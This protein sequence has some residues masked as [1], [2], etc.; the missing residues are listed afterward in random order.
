MRRRL[1]FITR[2]ATPHEL[3][4]RPLERVAVGRTPQHDILD[5]AR[6]R[7]V[8][9]G[10]AASAVRGQLHRDP[11]PRHRQIGMVICRL[12]QVANRI[13]Q[14][15]RRRPPIG[16][17]DPTDPSVFEGTA[18]EAPSAAQRSVSRRRLSLSFAIAHSM[19]P[20][21]NAQ[22]PTPKDKRSL[23]KLGIGSWRLTITSP[24]RR[25]PGAPDRS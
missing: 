7:K 18:R 6:Q 25:P 13:H 10:D 17:V 20:T 16:L 2:I 5:S 3:V 19:L 1:M 24:R 23:G 4:R 21:T 22:S 12:R 8:L 15:Q 11:S 14:H 9:V